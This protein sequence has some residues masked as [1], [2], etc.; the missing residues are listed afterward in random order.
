[1]HALLHPPTLLFLQILRYG[2][3]NGV[4]FRRQD[5]VSILEVIS[6]PVFRGEGL[7]RGSVLY[8]FRS[9][10]LHHGMSPFEGD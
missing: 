7:E 6:V 10:V 8:T 4:P 5:L 9:A 1:M 2:S 3:R